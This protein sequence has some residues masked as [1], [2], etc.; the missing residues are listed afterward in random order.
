MPIKVPSEYQ[1]GDTVRYDSTWI[2]GYLLIEAILF[3]IAIIVLLVCLVSGDI[4]F[5]KTIRILPKPVNKVKGIDKET[6]D[7]LI[8]YGQA[9]KDS[10]DHHRLYGILKSRKVWD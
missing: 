2:G 10:Q 1:W 6:R 9:D 5:K 3:G 7:L 4:E 8:E